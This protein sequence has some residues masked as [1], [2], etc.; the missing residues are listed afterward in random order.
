MGLLDDL[1][2]TAKPE[3][4][5]GTQ[6]P[7]KPR[8]ESEA[9]LNI[10]LPKRYQKSDGTIVEK[11][12][13]TPFGLPLQGMRDN[14]VQRSLPTTEDGMI[15][16]KVMLAGNEFRDELIRIALAMEPGEEKMIPLQVRIR[17]TKAKA[18][19]DAGMENGNDLSVL[20]DLAALL[21][22]SS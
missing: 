10:G 15:H 17:R 13:S 16:R 4:V 2:N 1:D 18:S 22:P 6:Q 12:I 21:S 11:F 3:P 9:W 8:V 19:L 5:N 14:E 20:G 7:A